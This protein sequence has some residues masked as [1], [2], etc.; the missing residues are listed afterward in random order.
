MDYLPWPQPRGV[1]QELK[2]S[3]VRGVLMSLRQNKF[4]L[5]TCL[6]QETYFHNP[7]TFH[8]SYIS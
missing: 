7:D 8:S 5:L 3:L 4:V 2:G 1:W 6:R